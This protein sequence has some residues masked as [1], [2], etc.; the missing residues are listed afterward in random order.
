MALIAVAEFLVTKS[1]TVM[2]YTIVLLAVI[3]FAIASTAC[4]LSKLLSLIFPCLHGGLPIVVVA[5]RALA[6]SLF[7]RLSL[8]DLFEW[9]WKI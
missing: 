3:L 1:T 9:I 8:L 7:A 6:L 5:L 2:T 4:L